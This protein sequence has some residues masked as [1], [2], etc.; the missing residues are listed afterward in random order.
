MLFVNITNFHNKDDVVPNCGETSVVQAQLLLSAED[1][2]D[3]V[4]DSLMAGR[5]FQEYVNSKLRALS[6]YLVIEE[7]WFNAVVF[8]ILKNNGL[9]SVS[10]ENPQDV[11][12]TLLMA[13]KFCFRDLKP[14][15]I[16][17]YIHLHRFRFWN[18]CRSSR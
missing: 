1:F 5:E 9:L 17:H 11:D 12:L 10:P 14:I 3:L 4:M 15:G 7:D 6:P 2:R 8:Q 16:P 18:G 13:L